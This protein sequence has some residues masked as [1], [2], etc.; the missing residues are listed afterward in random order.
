MGQKPTINLEFDHD[1]V[2]YLTPFR[3]SKAANS[4]Q[5]FVVIW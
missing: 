1:S 3:G 5:I 4:G 2:A